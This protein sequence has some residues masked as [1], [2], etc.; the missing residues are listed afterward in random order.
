M[1]LDAMEGNTENLDPYRK[2]PIAPRFYIPNDEKTVVPGINRKY[3]DYDYKYNI[4]KKAYKNYQEGVRSKEHPEWQKYINEMNSN[5]ELRFIQF[6]EQEAKKVKKLQNLIKEEP[7]N[8]KELEE[9]L[10]D[11]KAEIA[12]KCYEML[13]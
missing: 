8:K 13:K 12:V 3:Y 7:K 6:F 1:A 5:G 11:V 2:S 9:K 10:I 4:A